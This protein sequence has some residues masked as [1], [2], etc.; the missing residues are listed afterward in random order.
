LTS[1]TTSSSDSSPTRSSAGAAA[2]G[3]GRGI[4]SMARAVAREKPSRFFSTASRVATRAALS[5]SRRCCS[6]AAPRDA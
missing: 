1:G 2:R 4:A 6:V 3:R 5:N